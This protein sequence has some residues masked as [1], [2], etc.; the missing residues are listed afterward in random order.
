M[1]GNSRSRLTV[2]ACPDQNLPEIETTDC[3]PD[4]P[5]ATITAE[6][7]KDSYLEDDWKMTPVHP[8][9]SHGNKKLDIAEFSAPVSTNDHPCLIEQ[10]EDFARE[11]SDASTPASRDPLCPLEETQLSP[12]IGVH[13]EE[14]QKKPSK[15]KTSKLLHRYRE[16][17]KRLLKKVD[18]LKKVRNDCSK[19]SLPS[20]IIKHAS[21]YL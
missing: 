12:A 21:K 9:L 16:R 19:Y 5:S 14:S 17:V 18:V 15:P 10:P 1:P 7:L 6:G 13:A 2:S 20:D 4:D 8:V 3:D 11:S